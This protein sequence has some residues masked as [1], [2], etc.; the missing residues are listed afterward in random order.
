MFKLQEKENCFCGCGFAQL[1]MSNSKIGSSFSSLLY[2]FFKH[3]N[4]LG[5]S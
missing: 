3:Q 2:Y 4:L 1:S 5:V